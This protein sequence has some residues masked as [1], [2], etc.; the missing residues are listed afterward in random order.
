MMADMDF[1]AEGNPIPTPGNPA[2]RDNL[3]EWRMRL[4]GFPAATVEAEKEGRT[5]RAAL[6]RLFNDDADGEEKCE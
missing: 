5:S 6:E 2:L 3:S 1:D 4:C